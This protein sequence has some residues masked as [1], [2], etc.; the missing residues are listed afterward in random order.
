MCHLNYLGTNRLGTQCLAIKVKTKSPKVPSPKELRSP[1][2]R[3]GA[4]GWA[5]PAAACQDIWNSPLGSNQE[6]C[7]GYAAPFAGGEGCRLLIW[8]RDR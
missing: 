1:D 7:G 4:T 2:A 6:E 3:K 5:G 8:E